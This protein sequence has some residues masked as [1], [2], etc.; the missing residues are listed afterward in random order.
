MPTSITVACARFT[1]NDVRSANGFGW[2]G[3][4]SVS[5]GIGGSGEATPSVTSKL[6]EAKRVVVANESAGSPTAVSSSEIGCVPAASTPSAKLCDQTRAVSLHAAAPGSSVSFRWL[7]STTWAFVT[8]PQSY[9]NQPHRVSVVGCVMFG[10]D[11]SV[12]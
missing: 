10:A 11:G 12:E 8:C 7:E 9:G 2:L 3:V 1:R 4:A 5:I 6:N